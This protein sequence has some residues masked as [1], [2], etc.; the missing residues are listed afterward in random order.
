MSDSA[1]ETSPLSVTAPKRRNRTGLSLQSMLLI[2]LLFVSILSNV[3]IGVIGYVN[4]TDSLR[5]AAVERLTEIRDARA[6]AVANLFTT[7]ENVMVVHAGGDS[8]KGASVAFNEAFAQ[9]AAPLSTEPEAEPTWSAELTPEQSATLDSYYRNGYGP[10]LAEAIGEPVDVNAFLP[11]G[12]AQRY[13]QFHYTAQVGDFDNAIQVNDAGDGSTWSEVHAHYHPYFSRM[14]Q[15]L[16][17]QDILLLDT[18]GNVVYSV[19]KGIDL[20]TNLLTG[21]YAM[22][23]LAQAYKSAL[24]NRILD[25]VIF[26]DFETY[27]PSIDRPAAWAVSLIAQDGVVTGAMVIEM[28]IERIA[29][30]MTADESWASSG[31]GETGEAY[32]VGRDGLMRS[33]SRMLIENSEMYAS[34]ALQMGVESTS[35]DQA[36][37][38]GDTLMLQPVATEAVQEAQRG[39]KGTVRASNYLGAETLAAFAPLAVEGLG[40]V[41]VAEVATSEAFAPVSEFTTNLLISSAILVLIVSIMSLFIAQL[42]V[43]PLNRLRVAAERISAGEQGV[44]VDAGSA[45]EMVS[46]ANAFN[47]MSR[48]LQVKAD[49]LEEQRRENDK[50][51]RS[52][53]PET[54]ARRYR[55]GET[56]TAQDHQEV[57]VVY[58]DIVGFDEFIRS[59]DSGHALEI[60]N[61]VVNNFD[62]AARR[63]G[64]ERVRTTRHGYL[65]SCGM[66]VPRVDA[67]RRIVD[68]ADEMAEILDRFDGRYDTN[69]QLRAGIDFGTVTS[70][71]I[72]TEN[73]AFDLWGDAASHALYIQ[74][75][76]SKY[77][78]YVTDRVHE[79]LADS[80]RFTDAGRIDA[81]GES[82]R[83]WRLV[84]E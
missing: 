66:T 50:L 79:R 14:L 41:V 11:T 72:G 49:L 80:S 67:V 21:P 40:W 31:L 77:G 57:A 64:V 8:V 43:R 37:A 45:D 15:L 78:I 62:Q 25:S 26:T 75:K 56:T 10:A 39:E 29:N 68:F 69:L 19:Y 27:R 74:A 13:L 24:S 17:Y 30:A 20:G 52:F 1:L 48:S 38:T 3:V 18:E 84:R 5:D 22:S 9:I 44:Q 6:R 35:V 65:A 16:D 47:E 55:E 51:L 34:A 81:E 46:L 33:P 42:I 60:L 71:L 58:A 83:V 7:I 2:M 59:M 53:M 36:L 4:G 70:G 32:L 23:N 61:E 63:Y 73:I 28:P 12:S 54:L 82:L 76:T